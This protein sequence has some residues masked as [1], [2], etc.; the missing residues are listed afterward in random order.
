MY[1]TNHILHFYQ[2]H[3]LLTISPTIY[4]CDLSHNILTQNIKPAGKTFQYV[5]RWGNVD[6][7]NIL[8]GHEIYRYVKTLKG[9]VTV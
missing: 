9:H 7:F 2:F 3:Q 1:A 5:F 8:N 4:T 6:D